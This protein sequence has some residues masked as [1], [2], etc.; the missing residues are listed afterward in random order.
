MKRRAQNPFPGIARVFDRHGKARWRFRRKGRASAYIPGEYGSEEFRSAYLK[1][2][3]GDPA[4]ASVRHHQHGTFNWLIEHYKRTP[5][6][7]K[8]API[9]Q[10]N[11]GNEFDR[12]S[13]EYGTRHLSTLR[14]EHVEAI[15]A[16]KADSPA[17][18]NRLLKL[19]RRLSRFGIKKGLRSDD[20]TIGAER[21]KENPDG[22]HT[23][24]EPEVLH[25]E[26][27][28]GIASKPVLAL[29]LILNTG[30]ARQDVASL[31]RQNV[32]DGRISYRRKKTGGEVDLPILE[33]LLEVLRNLPVDRLLFL[34]HTG[35][36]PYKAT[37]FGNWFHDQCVAAGLPHCS[38]HG[39]RKAGATRLAN[40]GASEL[41]I[42]AFLG[43]RTPDEARTYVKK[44]NRSRL[45]DTGMEKV[46]RAKS[47]QGLSNRVERLDIHRRKALKKKGN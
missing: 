27:H 4:E 25:F 6:W 20:P 19:L 41:E 13:R 31:G 21:Y 44:F 26:E 11:L 22:F 43:H 39:L 36:R 35:D 5:K 9:S 30:A 34:T 32:R 23:W 7:K 3:S 12:F 40:A 45:G 42:M 18:A 46:A 10:K 38:S 8:L 47:E 37:S 15:I 29:R 14:P 33:E 16:K 28:H 17:A 24:T 1:A 2:A